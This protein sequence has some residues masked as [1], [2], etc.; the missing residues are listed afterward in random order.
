MSS[1][2]GLV[3][4]RVLSGDRKAYAEFIKK[5]ERPIFNSVLRVVGDHDRAASITQQAFVAAYEKLESYDPTRR[6]YNW[7]F[8]IARNACLNTIKHEKNNQI[9]GDDL[10]AGDPSPED[11]LL[12]GEETG[13]VHR[14]LASLVYEYRILLVLRHYLDQSYAEMAVTVNL[15]ESTVRSRLHRARSLLR[16]QLQDLGHTA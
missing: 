10:P 8:A 1:G 13:Q 11:R 4:Q 14:A 5:Y 2:D 12:Q 3:V 16:D 6:F 15:P 7:L 9:L